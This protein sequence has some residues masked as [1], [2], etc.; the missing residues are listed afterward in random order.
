MTYHDDLI[1]DNGQLGIGGISDKVDLNGDPLKL[2]V[3]GGIRV[4]DAFIL[5][6]KEIILSDY[7]KQDELDDVAF[8][9]R[10]MII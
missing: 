3:E 10:Q 6:D 1:L 9:G 4:S 8:S 2:N 5:R 7:V